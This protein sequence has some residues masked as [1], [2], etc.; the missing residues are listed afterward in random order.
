MTDQTEALSP[1]AIE[2]A[3]RAAM[4][5]KLKTQFFIGADQ[6]ET[7]GA[8]IAQI[9]NAGIPLRQNYDKDKVDF[10]TETHGMLIQVLKHRIKKKTVPTGEV[11]VAAV[12]TVESVGNFGDAGQ[13]FLMESVE[14]ILAS[15]VINAIRAAKEGTDS[16]IPFTIEDF[17]TKRT[18]T[19]EYGDYNKVAKVFVA[20]LKKGKGFEILTPNILRNVLM[21]TEMAKSIFPNI[22]QNWW[23][24]VLAKM[25]EYCG[26]STPNYSTEIFEAWIETRDEV[27]SAIDAEGLS[28]DALSLELEAGLAASDDDEDTDDDGDDLED[29]DDDENEETQDGQ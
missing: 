19:S 6:L 21:S 25:M 15:R 27:S 5:G 11:L 14:G 16:F 28:L 7:A 17:I 23:E 3:T 22:Q 4:L 12:P 29:A 8:I 26:K 1:E 20:A 18:I 2:Q 24:G 10:P 9:Q 13:A